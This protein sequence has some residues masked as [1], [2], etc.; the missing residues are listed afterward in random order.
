MVDDRKVLNGIL[1]R[2]RTGSPWA[3]IPERYGR[4]TACYNRFVRWRKAGH[5]DC[6]PVEISQGCDGGMGRL[7][8]QQP[9]KAQQS[10][11]FRRSPH[12]GAIT[13]RAAWSL[14]APPCRMRGGAAFSPPQRT[15]LHMQ[16]AYANWSPGVAPWDLSL[17]P[18]TGLNQVAGS[19][20]RSLFRN[21]QGDASIFDHFDAV[22]GNAVVRDDNVDG[23]ET[24]YDN[25]RCPVKL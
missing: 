2:F 7:R 12:T 14:C 4:Y 6:L 18:G 21:N 23:V 5:W 3:D 17:W 22:I 25:A 16:F 24:A 19:L 10:A 9:P 8:G 13:E 15:N 1:W 20:G 11:D